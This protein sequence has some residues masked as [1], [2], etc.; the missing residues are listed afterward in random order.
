MSREIIDFSD[1]A[2][3]IPFK[4]K[5]IEYYIP[6][7]NKNQIRKIMEINKKRKDKEEKDS[8]I[9]DSEIADDKNEEDFE[10]KDT[11][12]FDDQD[13]M[14][15]ISVYKKENNS[16]VEI[17]VLESWPVVLKNRIMTLIRNYSC[18]F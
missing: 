16:P 2:E 18:S 3:E 12:Y 15:C 11:E 5:G 8:E 7:F 13:E 10:E 1:C 4:Y 17:S 9:A 14:L 6:A